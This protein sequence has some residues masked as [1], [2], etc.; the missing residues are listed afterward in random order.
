MARPKDTTTVEID[1]F[2]CVFTYANRYVFDCDVYQGETLVAELGC[3]RKG[4]INA[5]HTAQAFAKEAVM[6]AKE[7]LAP[8]KE[9][10]SAYVD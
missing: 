1:G 9:T 4:N 2:R 5:F 7:E 6:I 10:P 3:P 8:M